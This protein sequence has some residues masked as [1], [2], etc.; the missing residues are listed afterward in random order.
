MSTAEVLE[1]IAKALDQSTV[2]YMLTGSFASAY[3]GTPRSTQD[4]GQIEDAA[5]ILRV[6]QTLDRSYI[7]RWV[8]QL[9]LEDAWL[10][11]QTRAGT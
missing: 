11:A 2:A 1:R 7:E 5:A 4:V 3:Y 9:R 6:R 8:S 10:I